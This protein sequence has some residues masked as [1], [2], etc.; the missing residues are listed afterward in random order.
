LRRLLFG[1]KRVRDIARRPF[2]AAVLARATRSGSSQE[3]AAPTSEVEL[4]D[5]WWSHGGYNSD[6]TRVYHRQRTLIKLAKAGAPALGRRIGLNGFDLDAVRELKEDEIIRD[7]VAGHAVQFAHDIFFEWSFLHLLIEHET[8][9]IEQIRSVGEPPVLGR[10]VELLSQAGYPAFE[11]WQD[12]L[13]RLEATPVRPQWT[14]AWLTAPFG[15]PR[16]WENAEQ[17]TAA[18]LGDDAKHLAQLAVWFQAEKTQANPLILGR[19][20]LPQT[21]SPREVVRYADALAWP[22]DLGSWSRFLQWILRN[23]ESCPVTILADI[24]SGFEVWQ[25]MLADRANGI[26][27]A[28]IGVVNGWL[29]DIEDREHAEEFRFDHGRWGPLSRGERSELE[30]R[31]RNL[32]LRSA[33][34]E[35]ERV[36]GYLRRVQNRARLRDEVFG[37]VIAW[38][39]TLASTHARD[40]VNLCLAALIDELPADVAK[41][42]DA[43]GLSHSVSV[44]DWNELAIRDT[45]GDFSP[46]SPL[47]EPLASLFPAAPAQ[48]QE[49]VRK[50]TNH[51]VTAWRELHDLNRRQEGTPIPLELEFPWGRQE[52]WGDG[53]VYMWARGQWAPPPVLC[54]LMALEKWAFGEVERGRV[55]DEVIQ[56]VVSGHESCAVLNIAVALALESNRVSRVTLPLAISQ[57]IWHW[58]IGRYVTDLG[59]VTNLIGF[60]KP[61]DL[62]HA[63]AV[64]SANGRR[65]R[66]IEVRW[67]AQLFVLNS[68]ESLRSAAQ[69]AILAFPEALPFELEEE[70][71]D[72]GRVADLRR[73]AE[74]W[75]E[76][77]R[78]ENYSAT[79]APDGRGTLIALENPRSSEPDIVATAQRSE[80][81][82]EQMG[83][84]NWIYDSFER[85]TVSEKRPLQQALDQAHRLDRDDLFTAAHGED[86][87]VDMDQS[88]V[89]G[90]AAIAVLYAEELD[91]KE[92]QWSKG[93]MLRAWQTPEHHG[94]LWSSRSMPLQH[95]CLYSARG[96][97]GLI[98]RGLDIPKV[99]VALLTL[100]GHPLEKVSETALASALALWDIDANFAWIA[101]NLAI[102][103]S[104]GSRDR[105]VSAYGYD[106]ATAPDQMAA[107]VDVALRELSSGNTFS[108]LQRIPPAWVFAA[109]KPRDD[110]LRFGGNASEPIWREPDEFLRWDFLPKIFGSIPIGAV[111]AD[112][113]RRPA[114]LS[115]CDDLLNWTLERMN[116][117]WRSEKAKRR[118]RQGTELLEWRRSLLGFLAHVALRLEP[119]DVQ[120]R[121]LDRIFALENEAAES[122]I[123]PFVDVITAA[124]IFDA[125]QIAPNATTLVMAC[126]ERTL[127]DHVWARARNDEGDLFGYDVPPLVKLYLF[128][129]IE[130]A[131][132]AARFANRDWREVAAILPIVDRFVREVGDVPDVMSAFLTLCERAVEHYPVAAFVDQVTAAINRQERTPVGWRNSTL[133][134]RIAG[135]I[136]AFAEREQP[137]ARQSA[138]A[139]LRVLDRLV[140]MGDRRSA[141]LQMSETFKD[142][143]L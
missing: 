17:F 31:L 77:G 131:G 57:R 84:L 14:R 47:R 11:N 33:R 1:E 19:S 7:V 42:P 35:I 69:T 80:R 109:P 117:S 71:Q 111:M 41:R 24:V 12:N 66:R 121:F 61:S 73:T 92:L 99:Q 96:L 140:D 82:N 28:I 22:S 23:I 64:R 94:E 54:G 95:P 10:T 5:V 143:R 135:L 87:T 36:R 72:G 106:H 90:V 119:D 136:H 6:Q 34:I 4:I 49:L 39:P 133:P 123:H 86:H 58:D 46:A 3:A 53:Q 65:A 129:S 45:G 112:A 107:T 118:E 55:V 8:D 116:P 122:L 100:A 79:P 37:K 78:I 110:G 20:M 125:P 30:D 81:M 43:M 32:L 44:T 108:T 114:F 67:L 103:L 128:V 134:G 98:R 142:V 63:E 60:I 139:M 138:Q 89:A 130:F 29:E 120:R 93:V 97:P 124:G 68:D 101:L 51:A 9:W 27:A 16:F 62:P 102:R 2:F 105:I 52:F 91:S 56:E 70:K 40:M 21:L 50:I 76:V 141:A 48:A 25:N 83:L 85:R 104:V 75:A 126:L 113:L 127:K 88:L 15:S 74:I 38:T 132:G 59:G 13:R 26:S 18:M 137:L 115:F